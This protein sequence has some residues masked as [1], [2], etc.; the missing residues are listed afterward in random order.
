MRAVHLL[1]AQWFVAVE[2]PNP[3]VDIQWRPKNWTLRDSMSETNMSFKYK[4]VRAQ[5]IQ[6]EKL[7]YRWIARNPESPTVRQLTFQ[8][9]LWVPKL[10]QDPTGENLIVW[11]RVQCHQVGAMLRTC[12]SCVQTDA[13]APAVKMRWCSNRQPLTHRKHAEAQRVHHWLVEA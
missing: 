3:K 5:G 10:G 13:N 9:A 4:V 2:A 6:M 7:D 11:H 1:P 8:R 12:N